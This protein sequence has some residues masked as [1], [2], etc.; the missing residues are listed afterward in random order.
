MNYSVEEDFSDSPIYQAVL[1]KDREI[2]EYLL[3]RNSNNR[4][5]LKHALSLAR[6]F[7]L[8]DVVGLILKSLGLD[9]QRRFLNFG[10]LDLVEIKPSWIYPSLGLRYNTNSLHRHRRHKSLEYVTVLINKRNSIDNSSLASF[11]ISNSFQSQQQNSLYSKNDPEKGIKSLMVAGGVAAMMPTFSDTERQLP[12]EQF[13]ERSIDK[14]ASLPTRYR[15]RH[16][17]GASRP[18]GLPTVISSPLATVKSNSMPSM[19]N[20]MNNL[21]F[22]IEE[23]SDGLTGRMR[24]SESRDTPDGQEETGGGG[25]R[26]EIE[27][28]TF[29][30]GEERVPERR[31]TNTLSETGSTHV[32]FST[33]A[34]YRKYNTDDEHRS[35]SITTLIDE[36]ENDE[37]D[38][39]VP[40]PFYSLDAA[41][42]AQTR[43][44]SNYLGAKLVHRAARK[45]LYLKDKKNFISSKSTSSDDLA[46]E[47]LSLSLTLKDTELTTYPP[48]SSTKQPE[49]NDIVDGGAIPP[50]V[51]PPPPPSLSVSNSSVNVP[52]KLKTLMYLDL[53]SNKMKDLESLV[54]NNKKIIKSLKD[55]TTMDLKQN[56][57]TELPLQ[58]IEV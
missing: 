44:K 25:E 48:E 13:N 22:D 21:S 11:S 50:L 55:V 45:S 29:D 14:I 31:H 1:S 20:N 2:V 51:S 24:R 9:R 8:N 57:L 17:Q 54:E 37:G 6:A 19:V 46:S 10:G 18:P 3:S 53:S 36:N 40:N 49:G 4:R 26:D 5:H 34:K 38:M 47:G 56:S 28:D 32:L 27:S 15:Q 52:L 12:L 58:L 35:N 23:D 7:E 42:L 39:T 43:Q 41:R 30:N 16:S 33:L